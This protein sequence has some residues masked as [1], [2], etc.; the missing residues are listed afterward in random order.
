MKEKVVTITF[1]GVQG[2]GKSRLL[3]IA[4]DAIEAAGHKILSH[5]SISHSMTAALYRSPLKKRTRG[6][7]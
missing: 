4:A 7:G 3:A 1:E 2:S 5:D 6:E